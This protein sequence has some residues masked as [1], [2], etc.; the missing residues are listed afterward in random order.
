MR[1]PLRGEIGTVEAMLLPYLGWIPVFIFLLLPL[2]WTVDDGRHRIVYRLS[3]V[4]HY[5]R[6]LYLRCRLGDS[7]SS[8]GSGNSNRDTAALRVDTGPLT[9]LADRL[10]LH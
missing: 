6:L 10:E 9:L 3:S 5:I 2:C 8:S 1:L 4:V 7:G